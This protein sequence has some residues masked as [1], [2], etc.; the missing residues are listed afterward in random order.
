MKSVYLVKHFT[1]NKNQLLS[2][3]TLETRINIYNKIY[4]NNMN[5]NLPGSK[6]EVHS[7]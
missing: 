4:F 3:I 1:R 7:C 6:V 2:A 5:V